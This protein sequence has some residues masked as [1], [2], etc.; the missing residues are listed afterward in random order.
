M[1]TAKTLNGRPRPETL[2]HCAKQ[3]HVRGDA[4]RVRARVNTARSRYRWRVRERYVY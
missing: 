1:L 2:E 3:V 4:V